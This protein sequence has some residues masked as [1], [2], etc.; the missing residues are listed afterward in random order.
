MD[1]R[2]VLIYAK[3]LQEVRRAYSRGCELLCKSIGTIALLIMSGDI[4]PVRVPAG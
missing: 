4:N 3:R 1:I 2:D